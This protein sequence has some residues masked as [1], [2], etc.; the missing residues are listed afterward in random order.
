M[1]SIG[2]GGRSG[3]VD[4]S[5]LPLQEGERRPSP[6]PKGLMLIKANLLDGAGLKGPGKRDPKFSAV[7]LNPTVGAKSQRRSYLS[8][9]SISCPLADDRP[10]S[11]ENAIQSKWDEM[12]LCL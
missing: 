11:T 9:I 12:C 10:G 3:R 4:A 8:R 7:A 1:E 2:C 5:D 6:A